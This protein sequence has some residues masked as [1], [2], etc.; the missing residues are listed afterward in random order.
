MLT[1]TIDIGLAIL[2]APLSS[3]LTSAILAGITNITGH[4]I[5]KVIS[6][7]L[8][9]PLGLGWPT[10]ILIGLSLMLGVAWLTNTLL[11]W[12]GSTDLEHTIEAE[13]REGL[14]AITRIEIRLRDD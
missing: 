4:E 7:I 12:F 13:L 10:C 14:V 1:L 2:S 9:L 6:I 5:D 3:A 8:S 11:F